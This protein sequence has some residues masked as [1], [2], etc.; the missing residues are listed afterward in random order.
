MSERGC[1]KSVTCILILTVVALTE[2][3]SLAVN[4]RINPNSNASLATSELQDG[5]PMTFSGNAQVSHSGIGRIAVSQGI[6][7][8]QIATGTLLPGGRYMLTAAHPFDEINTNPADLDVLSYIV[9][10][11]GYLR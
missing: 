6:F 11:N 2:I 7:G 10:V 1:M 4:I 9:N 8:T 3:S 5:Q